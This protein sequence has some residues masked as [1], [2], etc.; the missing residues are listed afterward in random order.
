M[1]Q[2]QKIISRVVACETLENVQIVPGGNK[3]TFDVYVNYEPKTE[4]I[5]F[6]TEY[7]DIRKT[8]ISGALESFIKE[9]YE[10][11]FCGPIPPFCNNGDNFEPQ[12][13]IYLSADFKLY[14][15]IQ[16]SHNQQVYVLVKEL[17][18]DFNLE[19]H[20]ELFLFCSKCLAW[21]LANDEREKGPDQ[22]ISNVNY[23]CNCK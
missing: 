15:D 1:L 5:M 10:N 9:E 4:C 8:S 21:I 19:W 11:F 20:S 16:K 6:Y 3:D 2:G 14:N 7:P 12:T 22:T 23:A 18:P 17:L 13:I